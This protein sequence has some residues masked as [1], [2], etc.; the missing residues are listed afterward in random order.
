MGSRIRGNEHHFVFLN[1]EHLKTLKKTVED[2]AYVHKGYR[3]TC[4]LNPWIHYAH[5]GLQ[6]LVNR[7]SM[8]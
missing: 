6:V 7:Q 5:K 2:A 3:P 4:S 8:F 1:Y